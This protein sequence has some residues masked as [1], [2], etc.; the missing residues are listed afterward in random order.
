MLETSSKKQDKKNRRTTTSPKPDKDNNELIIADK[1]VEMQHQEASHENELSNTQPS[2]FN[3]LE[4]FEEF[5]RDSFIEGSGIAPEIFAECVEFHCDLEVSPGMDA[6]TPIHDALGWKFTRFGHQVKDKFYGALLKNE[7]GSIW[8]AVLSFSDEEGRRPYIYR[9][10]ND[11]GDRV[12]LPPVPP[13]IRKRIASRYGVEVPMEGSFWEW[14]KTAT[15]V[16]I[17]SE[18]TG[19]FTV[20]TAE[21]KPLQIPRIITEGAKKGLAL[22]TQGYVPLPLYGCTCG[23]RQSLIPDLKQFNQDE[24]IWL[25]ALDRDKKEKTKKTVDK[26]KRELSNVLSQDG[27]VNYIEDIVWSPEQGKG[28]DDLI[29]ISGHG[30][31]DNAYARALARLEKQFKVSSTPGDENPKK[32][33]NLP[34]DEASQRIAEEYRHLLKFNNETK[35]W[36][37]YLDRRVDKLDPVGIWV[38]ESTEVVESI[39]YK[40]LKSW[41]AHNF[42]ADYV[43]SV[44]KILR[45]ELIEREWKE[46]SPREWLP[47]RNGVVEITTG[48]LHEHSPGFKLTWQ[49]PRDYC[50]EGGSWDTINNF[51]EH[52]AEGDPA[53]KEILICYCNAVIKGRYDLQRFLHLIGLGGT[54]KG[55]FSRL[56]T[57]LIGNENVHVTTL[58]DWCTNRFEGANAYGKRLVLFPDED[59]YRGKIGKFLSL[60][61]EDAV[62]A[63]IKGRTAFNFQYS[64]MVMVLSNHPVF[65]GGSA[66]RAKRRTIPV[67]CNKVVPESERRNLTTD[68]EPEISAFTNYLL[69]IPDDHVTSVIRG[70]KEV[71]KCTL[72]FWLNQMKGDSVASWLNDCL[73]HDPNSQTPIG[74]DMNEGANGEAITLFGSYVKNCR[75]TGDSPKS[76]KN[77]S[78]D[79]RELCLTVLGWQVEKKHA[80]TGEVM[81]GLRLRKVG[82]DDHIPTYEQHLIEMVRS[83]EESV[84]GGGEESR[85]ESEPLPNKEGERCEELNGTSPVQ[86][87]I[88]EQ[89]PVAEQEVSDIDSQENSSQH[90]QSSAA[91]TKKEF[92][93]WLINPTTLSLE[94]ESELGT[95]EVTADP[96]HGLG[97]ISGLIGYECCVTWHWPVGG[98]ATLKDV[99][100]TAA[101][102]FS[103]LA[104]R[105]AGEWEEKQIT[106]LWCHR[107]VGH[108]VEV[109]EGEHKGQRLLISAVD[110]KGI[111]LRKPSRN[112]SVPLFN[113]GQ[114]YQPHQ[115]KR[116]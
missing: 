113:N 5:I 67:A 61:G 46:A 53:I 84:R 21:E 79:L 87:T 20:V 107:H 47:F 43:T 23:G 96:T 41:N 114:F 62:R 55:T 42:G 85:E 9:S 34:P 100:I 76:S 14:F 28:V 86:Q 91:N 17:K 80:R 94:V 32:H 81:V 31:F 33:K 95:I 40:I 73:I 19:D 58:E 65:S 105:I 69:T 66:S 116:C 97:D 98:G 70:T 99:P 2:K 89:F 93:W 11:N 54:G 102:V 16:R 26:A 108:E 72:E 4:E 83:G 7:D 12:F 92:N 22:L 6:E 104:Q 111:T 78:P 112:F 3:S 82:L 88:F 18:N 8:Q 59:P 74:K 38:V 57:S 68:F 64:G 101:G 44:T 27:T 25:L 51:L 63:E 60:T 24:S 106:I 109:L 50:P 39:V 103:E 48:K 29:V 30:A 90:P 37:R 36:M 56:V 15:T 45:H 75:A 115:L 35:Q 10:P 110:A 49:L 1:T 77:F 52:L 13:S 71:A